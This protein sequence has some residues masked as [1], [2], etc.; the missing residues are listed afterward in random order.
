MELWFL[1]LGGWI[2]CGI[3]SSVIGSSKGRDAGSWFLAGLLLGPIGV[4]M[5]IGV[6][7]QQEAVPPA[8]AM[9]K[10]P[11]CAEMVRR[12]AIKCRYC[13][14]NLEPLPDPL[15]GRGPR[16]PQPGEH[17]TGRF[18]CSGCNAGRPYEGSIESGGKRYC[19]DCAADLGYASDG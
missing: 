11:V 17:F 18:N 7:G 6:T 3:A 10:C 8:S 13:G 5:A 4:L 16:S 2:V 14:E 15:P 19:A 1:I 9:R 12:E